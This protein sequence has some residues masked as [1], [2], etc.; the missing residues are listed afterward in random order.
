MA[1][2]IPILLSESK[3]TLFFGRLANALEIFYR[4]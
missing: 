2:T 4:I 3:I 1:S